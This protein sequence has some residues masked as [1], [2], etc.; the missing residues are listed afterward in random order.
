[1]IKLIY[2]KQYKY[3]GEKLTDIGRNVLFIIVV[4]EK[5]DLRPE[6]PKVGKKILYRCLMFS[7][8]VPK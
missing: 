8:N 6:L 3:L 5:A 2:V 4:Y 1:M 7:K